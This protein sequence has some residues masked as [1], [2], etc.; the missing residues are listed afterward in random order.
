MTESKEVKPL[1]WTD[2][3][4]DR[5][6]GFIHLADARRLQETQNIDLLDPKS[7]D[8]LFGGNPLCR[9]E[10]IG[11]LARPQ[12]TAAGLAYDEFAERLVSGPTTFVDATDALR[13]GL[14][15]FFRRLGRDDLAIVADR[16]WEAL[17]A[18]ADLRRTKASGTKVGEILAAGI[19]RSEREI[20]AELDRALATMAIPGQQSGS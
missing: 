2:A 8:V 12:W 17:A 14:S 5:W 16:A 20:D 19:Q 6:S 13:R 3:T 10:A 4:G 1:S 15:D 7:V 18:D 11:E 9:I